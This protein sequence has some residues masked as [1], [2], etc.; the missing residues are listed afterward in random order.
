MKHQTIY[1]EALKLSLK[2]LTISSE[3]QTIKK[4]ALKTK[5]YLEFKLYHLNVYH[6]HGKVMTRSEKKE[7]MLDE[8]AYDW[9]ADL[10]E[11]YALY[12]SKQPFI[13]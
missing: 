11:T 3:A 7:G 12:E 1:L 6:L 4:K 2:A 10:V 9:F 8:E 5:K 13:K